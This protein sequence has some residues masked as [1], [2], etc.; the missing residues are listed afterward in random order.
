MKRTNYPLL[1][2]AAIAL[3]ALD[4]GGCKPAAPAEEEKIVTEVAVQVGKVIRTDLHARVE[5]YGMV[6]TEPA[7]GGHPG[8]GARLAAP[9]AGIV[10]AVPDTEGQNVKAGDIVLRLDDRMAKAAME[11]AQHALA[12]AQQVAARQDRLKAI[13]GTSERVIQEAQQQ[14][15]AAQSEVASARAALAQVQLASPLDGVVAQ[16]NVSPGQA[17]DPNMVVAVIVDLNRL[18]ATASVPAAEAA[19]L[20]Q[21][22]P[23]ELFIASADQPAATGSVSFVSPSVDPKTGAALVRVA[24]PKDSGLR[25]GQFVRL[26]IV[27][28]ERPGRLA[29]PR[30][31][32]VKAEEGQVIFVVTRDNA[33]Q[34]AVKTGVRDGNLVEVEADGLKEGD[35][36][37]TVGAYGLP[38]ETKIKVMPSLSSVSAAPTV[39]TTTWLQRVQTIPLPGVKG[40]F[41]L[42]AADVPGQRLFVCAQDN[43]TLE[44]IDLKAG[45]RVRSVPD[46]NEPKWAAYRPETNRLYVATAGDGKVTVLDA[47][48]FE[49]IQAFQFKDRANNL[50]FDPAT[51]EMFVGV[52]KTD[53]A[54]G[55]IDTAAGRI[56]GQIEL[57][58]F[59]KQFELE[60][61]LI[62]VNVPEA[63]H[64]AVVD[65]AKKAVIATWPVKE[66]KENVPMGFDRAQHRL[67]IGCDPGKFVVFDTASGKSVASL[68]IPAG[69][70][71]L[72]Y[73]A[74]RKLIYISCGAGSVEVIQQTDADHYQNAGRIPTVAGAGT[75]LFV[76]EFARLYVLVPQSD[77]QVAEIRVFAARQ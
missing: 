13:D 77:K 57:A 43:H 7:K 44:V 45:R 32:V 68:D 54:L 61:N 31:S 75:S 9:A 1:A 26:R 73:D 52:G 11:K 58:S 55:I 8:G 16:I 62:Y 4:L 70:D 35:T 49:V 41:D 28:E 50:R 74:S 25:P 60:G 18:V 19:L 21:G 22:Q 30:E 36:I 37:V 24:L 46:F 42:M 27:S 66:A 64:I 10:L 76:P 5:A 6:E 34:K 29:V 20:K 23:A 12:F 3:I 67:F 40:G 72:S 33:V 53:G 14:V 47:Q 69:A 56:T 39:S 59:P 71:G 17:V 48:T 15:A 2:A 38:K 51:K 63:N 65:R